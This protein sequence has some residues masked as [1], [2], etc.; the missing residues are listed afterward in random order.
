L[1]QLLDNTSFLVQIASIPKRS[2][3]FQHLCSCVDA[4]CLTLAAIDCCLWRTPTPT[5]H[6]RL[7]SSNSEPTTA[8]TGKPRNQLVDILGLPSASAPT[9]LHGHLGRASGLPFLPDELTGPRSLR[10]RSKFCC[11]SD[12][13]PQP[14]PQTGAS[15]SKA[16]KAARGEEDHFDGIEETLRSHSG[17]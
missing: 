5:A 10:R 9:I 11:S 7:P 3:R 4:V 8:N 6:F 13:V 2:R 15:R 14:L 12:R 17:C 16:D 1:E